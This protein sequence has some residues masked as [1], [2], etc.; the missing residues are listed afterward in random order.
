MD[1]FSENLL[2]RAK[3]LLLT[4]DGSHF[5][6]G[7]LQAA[8]F[9]SQSCQA[10]IIV[11][12]VVPTRAES[13]GTANLAIRQR[14]QELS[15]HF[16]RIRAMA[17]DSGVEMEIVALGSS[18]LEKTLVEQARLRH[19][20]AILMGRH[21][22]ATRWS[23]LVGKTTLMVIAQKFPRVIVVPKE[24]ALT[25]MRILVAVNDT[26]N[27]R[28]AM[29]EAL[30]MTHICP[31]LREITV[32]SVASRPERRHLSERLVDEF[33][34]QASQMELSVPCTP[35]VEVGDPVQAIVAAARARHIDMIVLG[36]PGKKSKLTKMLKGSVAEKILGQGHCAMLVATAQD[37]VNT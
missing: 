1:R 34:Q 20:D 7:A 16:N 5:S 18:N 37:A 24:F 11:L 31:K 36:G 21:G 13:L 23:R 19:A 32:M 29:L 15:P 25:D 26:P 9:F 30:G 12:H 4:T 17:H 33:C 35:L 28:Q 8:I 27:S 10:K 14:W 3:T 2:D 6:E 22:I